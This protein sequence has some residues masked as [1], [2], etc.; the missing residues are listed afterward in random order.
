V[1][2]A[3]LDRL[4]LPL[5]KSMGIAVANVPGREQQRDSGVCR[6]YDFD[7]AAAICAG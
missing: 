3:G 4:D 1:T 7:F 5:L 2:G 6:N